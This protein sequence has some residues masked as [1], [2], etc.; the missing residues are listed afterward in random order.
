MGNQFVGRRVSVGVGMESTPGTEVAPT[1]WISQTKLDFQRKTTVIQNEGAMGRVEKYNDSAITEQWAEG[2]LEGKIRDITF[3]YLL[4]NLFGQVTNT[5]NADASGTVIDHLF[6]V[7][8]TNTPPTLTVV[9]KD[10][11]SNRRHGLASLD[12]LDITVQQNGWGMYS[13]N[14]KAKVGVTGTDSASYV[15]ENEFTI[16]HL[17]A[18]LAN[19]TSGI[20]AATA[21][22]VKSM[23]LS[24]KRQSNLFFPAGQIDPSDTTT[25]PFEVSGE[26]VLQYTDTTLEALWAAN[27]IQALSLAFKNTDVTIG[28]GANPAVTF[29]MPRVRLVTFAMSD[30]LDNVIEQTVGFTG[31]LDMT[32]GYL[33]QALL[34]NVKASY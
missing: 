16:K 8:N 4:Y 24:V 27:T 2:T 21:L 3:G 20:G 14:L 28:T 31:E 11:L 15:H 33:I 10:P 32:A 34:T 6:S 9:R 19:N 12:G 1:D 13:G 22:K 18:K 23:K 7:A 26:L 29:T 30:D 25:E 17:I 5:T